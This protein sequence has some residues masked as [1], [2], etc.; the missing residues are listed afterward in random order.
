M[1]IKWN[2]KEY[3]DDLVAMG[4]TRHLAVIMAKEESV[5]RH[6]ADPSNVKAT[7]DYNLSRRGMYP[8][9]EML[10]T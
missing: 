3:I 8:V 7:N 6:K 4:Y 5:K 1:A 9:R 10:E 2:P